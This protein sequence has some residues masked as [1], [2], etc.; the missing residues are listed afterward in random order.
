MTVP[1]CRI[2]R[3]NRAGCAVGSWSAV[4]TR[5]SLAR[6][7]SRTSTGKSGGKSGPSWQRAI[8]ELAKGDGLSRFKNVHLRVLFYRLRLIHKIWIFKEDIRPFPLRMWPSQHGNAINTFPYAPVDGFLGE[9]T[10]SRRTW[11]QF[12][13]SMWALSSFL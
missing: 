12:F 10:K 2:A 6:Y 9:A 7:G 13:C 11:V 3:D 1:T 8:A 4:V 5:I